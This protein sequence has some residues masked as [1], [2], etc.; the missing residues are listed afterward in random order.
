MNKITLNKP[1]MTKYCLRVFL[2][3]KSRFKN[4][5]ANLFSTYRIIT[6]RKRSL[7]K[8]NAFTLVW[9]FVHGIVGR[10]TTFLGRPP[11]P[12]VEAPLL[13]DPPPPPILFDTVNKR[14]VRILLE[15][16]LVDMISANIL[17][18]SVMGASNL[19]LRIMAISKRTPHLITSIT[20]RIRITV[21]TWELKD[22][23]LIIF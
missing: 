22:T 7:G 17:F 19:K 14:V 8:G 13:A 23:I 20:S 9:H 12:P 10:Q 2:L 5:F 3:H 1:A 6:A 16:N 18:Y 15:C 21:A 11:P 4:N